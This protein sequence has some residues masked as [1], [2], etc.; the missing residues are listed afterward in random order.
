MK[1]L[2]RI[3]LILL[4]FYSPVSA[5]EPRNDAALSGLNKTNV[6]FDINQGDPSVL[7]LRLKLIDQTYRQL[8]DFGVSTQFVLAFRGKAS[9]YITIGEDYV[10]PA[11]LPLKHKIEE[12]IARFKQQGMALEQCALAAGMQKIDIN[13]FLPQIEVVANGYISI[14][15][16]QNK[17]YALVSMD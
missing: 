10:K 16:Y 8:H 4:L 15:G 2:F 6:I 1:N 13:E 14:I 17:G 5:A 7:L 3:G 9:R 12:K 11:D